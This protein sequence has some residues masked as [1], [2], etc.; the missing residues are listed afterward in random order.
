[1]VNLCVVGNA[2]ELVNDPKGRSGCGSKVVVIKKPREK[3]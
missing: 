1:M 3:L 2:D